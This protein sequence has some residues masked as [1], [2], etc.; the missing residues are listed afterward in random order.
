M[1]VYNYNLEYTYIIMKICI[2]I[3]NWNGSTLISKC[4]KSLEGQTYKATIVV[5]DNASTDNSIDI[6]EKQFKNVILIKNS[7]NLGFAGGVNMGIRYAI[8][9]DFDMVALF[10]NDAEAD[11]NWLK[12]LV[13]TIVKDEQIGITTGKLM[14]T[15]GRHFDSTGDFY[16]KRGI[17]FPRGRNTVD[18]GQYDKTEPVFSASG[19]ASLYRVA[20]FKDVG[21][22]D[23]R[24]FAY[25]EDVDISFRAQLYGWKIW[26]TPSAIAYHA[27]SATSSTLGSFSQFHS[28]KNYYFL[29]F[30]NI[31]T[32][33]LIKYT[34]SLVYQSARS[35]VSSIVNFRFIN[36]LHAILVVLVHFPVVIIDRITIQRHRR[37]SIEYIDSLIS[38]KK[39]PVTPHIRHSL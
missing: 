13:N 9:H 16:T 25:F 2:I 5:I 4:I 36:Y 1:V 14:R 12:N 19:G 33:L 30:K 11:Q 22:F 3:P 20:M 6:I 34:P 35:F 29:L 31:P 27:V 8:D 23:E 37:V 39:P 10:N 17:P 24:F 18:T 32:K 38:E 15:D 7:T 21:L 28:N 26:Y